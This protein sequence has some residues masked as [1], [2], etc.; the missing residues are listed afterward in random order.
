[1]P[2][3]P[4]RPPRNARG[5]S[6]N[7]LRRCLF[8]VCPYMGRGR[9]APGPFD[10]QFRAVDPFAF[11]KNACGPGRHAGPAWSAILRPGQRPP[12]TDRRAGLRSGTFP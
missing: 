7:D 9:E 12:G 5:R 1:M 11:L 6:D 8:F 4:K 10:F 3:T 2:K